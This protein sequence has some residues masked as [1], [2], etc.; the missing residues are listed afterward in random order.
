MVDRQAREPSISDSDLMALTAAGDRGAFEQLI[1]R[2]APAVLR[3]GRAVTGDA[4]AA[5]DALQQTFLAVYQHASTFRGDS[6][7]RAWMLTIARNAAYR[8]RAKAS[9]EDLA[10]EP[11]IQLGV[12]AG[13]GSEDPETLAMAAEQR[14]TLRTAM[15][16]LSAQDREVLFLRDIEGL[17]APEAAALTGIGQRALKSRLHRARLRLA[18][19]LRRAAQTSATLEQGELP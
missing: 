4:A 19:A 3:L 8:M 2:H 1:R 12:E 5:E 9:R 13:W 10:E 18:A 16:T 11:W 7:V 6:S 17:A 15:S 14:D